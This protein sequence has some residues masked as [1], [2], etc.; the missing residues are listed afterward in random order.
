M[1]RGPK[2][3]ALRPSWKE[4]LYSL[5]VVAVIVGASIVFFLEASDIR[6]LMSA[7]DAHRVAATVASQSQR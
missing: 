5:L 6:S 1:T 2:Q 4:N 7:I 3:I